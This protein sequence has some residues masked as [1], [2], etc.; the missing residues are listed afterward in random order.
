MKKEAVRWVVS[1]NGMDWTAGRIGSAEEWRA[2]MK[3]TNIHELS[4]KAKET[5]ERFVKEMIR[6]HGFQKVQSA[7][8]RYKAESGRN[9]G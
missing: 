6:Q 4:E 3:E 7:V 1:G 9:R 8:L 5:L 2:K